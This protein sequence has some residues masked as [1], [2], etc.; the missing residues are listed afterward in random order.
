M[1]INVFTVNAEVIGP[2]DKW[3]LTVR[4]IAKDDG[5]KLGKNTYRVRAGGTYSAENY[6]QQYDG[7]TFQSGTTVSNIGSNSVIYGY[8]M[9]TSSGGSGGGTTPT[10]PSSYTITVKDCIDSQSGYV[11]GSGTYTV[12]AGSI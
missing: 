12:S 2:S 6:I 9:R 8:Y 11:L 3:N 4:D 7:Y 10:T 5:H 1:F